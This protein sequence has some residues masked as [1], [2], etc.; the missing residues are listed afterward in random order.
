MTLLWNFVRNMSVQLYI[1]VWTGAPVSSFPSL[2]SRSEVILYWR[3]LGIYV[4]D[5]PP[6]YRE[7]NGSD[8]P[9]FKVVAVRKLRMDSEVEA[10]IY[11]SA[12][13]GRRCL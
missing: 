13:G 7:Q 1:Y 4:V 10:V 11:T 9:G 5:G 12:A 6:S 8:I 2:V 3:L